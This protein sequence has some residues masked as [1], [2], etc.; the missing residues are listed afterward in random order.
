MLLS[1]QGRFATAIF[2]LAS[3][4]INH[5]QA[6]DSA[7]PAWGKPPASPVRTVVNNYFGTKVNDPYRYLE[8][9]T[10][11]EV[12]TW[13]KAQADF[14]GNVL[15]HISGRT[16]LMQRLAELNNASDSIA[17]LVEV[18][19]QQFY[20]LAEA[21]RNGRRLFV[22]NAATGGQKLLLDPDSMSS[23][24]KTYAIDF[25]Y[26]SLDAAMVIV[27]LSQGGSENSV[28]KII[29]VEDASQLP[30][31]IDR[32]GLNHH[33]MAWLPDSSGFFYNR[34]PKK[35]A[36][37]VGE[38]YNK[39]VVW[40]HIIAQSPDKDQALIGFGLNAQRPFATADLPHLITDANSTYV[41]AEVEHGD[42]V[43]RSLYVAKLADLKGNATPWQKLAAPAD[44]I[45]AAWLHGDQL[46]LLSYQKAPRGK[47]LQLDLKKPY[48]S[49]A[50]TVVKPGSDV[51]RGGAVAKDALYLHALA[52]GSSKLIRLDHSSLQTNAPELPFAGTIRQIGADSTDEGASIALEGWTSPKAVFKVS[53]EGRFNDVGIVQPSRADFSNIATRL[54]MVRS[55]DGVQVPMSLL[56]RKD[57]K[58]DSSNPTILSGYGA[59]GLTMSPNFDPM[60]L[61]WLEQGGVIA[62]AHVRGGGEL[63]E[64]WHQGA[65]ILNKANTALDFIAAAE[66]LIKNNYTSSTKLA[67]QGKSAGGITIGGAIN[68]RPE[69]FAAA[70]SGVGLS[71]LLRAELTPNGPPNIAE[72]GT[73]KNPA[74]F[75]AML[76]N[77]PYHNVRDGVA[78]PAVIITTG[79]NDPRV[80]SWMSS[81]LAARLQAAS[82]SGKPVLLRIDYDGGHG[83]GSSRA[84]I[85]AETADVWSFF[86]W[87]MDAP[88]Y[89]YK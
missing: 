21:G 42:A 3:L 44:Q 25:L 31:S 27:G 7:A 23:P 75:K 15:Q 53:A 76:S 83:M 11:G 82:S 86:L 28:L 59:Y 14:T 52:N 58:L 22:R 63:G 57:I 19:G 26:P 81:K 10:D 6:A 51:L 54:V 5:V 40:Q 64:D 46:Y 56:Y 74:Q 84:K 38:R 88:G 71:D 48:L 30:E 80:A 13:M 70:H 34:L 79:A 33:G 55:H 47:I 39:S 36:K 16:A 49:T 50:K 24:G 32:A 60:R 37:G 85:I 18:R 12:S 8:Q 9:L 67:G 77:S 35:D 65:H 66:Y 2:L 78:Y 1:S 43:D 29:K 4:C 61:A 69:L 41:I 72:F 68:R 62:I 45:H 87:Q 17:N 89:S 73:V 20:L